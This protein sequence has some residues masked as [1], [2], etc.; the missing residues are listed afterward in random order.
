M[1]AVASCGD[2]AIDGYA[3]FVAKRPLCCWCSAFFLMIVMAVIGPIAVF[4][5]KE[6]WAIG[7]AAEGFDPRG[8]VLAGAI[9]ARFRYLPI[10]ECEG[11]I[12]LMPDGTL[13]SHYNFYFTDTDDDNEIRYDAY[14]CHANFEESD[15]GRRLLSDAHQGH[16]HQQPQKW[17]QQSTRR[18]YA[19]DENL[20]AD[21]LAYD[22]WSGKTDEYMQ[23]VFTGDDLF[24]TSAIQGVCEADAE[25]R[26]I[27]G[28]DV[29]DAGCRTQQGDSG[30]GDPTVCA[31]SRSIG[32]YL[33][34]IKGYASCSEITD[35]DVAEMKA[36]VTTCRT[37][38]D[39][40]DL[41]G[42]CWDWSNGAYTTQYDDNSDAGQ[43]D[44]ET[45]E[46]GCATYNAYYDMFYSLAE[47]DYAG[48]GS[49]GAVQLMIPLGFNSFDWSLEAWS[50]IEAFSGR[51]YGGAKITA[52]GLD[53]KGDLFTELM[54]ADSYLVALVFLCV[55]IL[56]V[57]HSGS[58][59]ISTCAFFEMMM[60]FLWAFTF[61]EV[62]LW[63]PFF[64]F[65]NGVSLFLI[66]G[67]GADD[68][69]VYMD[70][71]KQSFA[72]LGEVPL[73]QRVAFT[74]KRAG[75]A[76][77]VTSLTTSSSFFAN[78][79][80]PIPALKCFGL[81]SG[82]VIIA[83]FFLMLTFLPAVVVM[84]E[85][86]FKETCC[87]CPCS[88]TPGLFEV[89]KMEP[90]EPPKQRWC[91]RVLQDYV[92]PVLLHPL[93][94]VAFVGAALGVA[95]WLSTEAP[96]LDRPETDYMQLLDEDHPIE[97]FEKT[98]RNR[99]DNAN[100][101]EGYFEFNYVFGVK[102]EDNGDPFEPSD[103]GSAQYVD[104]NVATMES[105]EWVDNFCESLVNDTI[106]QVNDYDTLEWDFTCYMQHFRQ[107]MFTDCASTTD[108]D[109]AGSV[110]YPERTT[111]CGHTAFPFSENDFNACITEWAL[112]R[113]DSDYDTGLWFDT[114]GSGDIKVI[115]IKGLATTKYSDVYNIGDA[116]YKDGKDFLDGKTSS[117]PAGSGLD[118]GFFSSELWFYSLQDAITEGAY[119]S[120]GLSI[121]LALAVILM[122]SQRAVAST[123]A[124]TTI[125][126]IVLSVT[127][128][129]VKEGWTLGVIESVV[130]SLAVGLSCDFA[131]HLSHAFVHGAY[132]QS[133]LSFFSLRGV[134]GLLGAAQKRATRAITELGVTVLMGGLTTLITGCWLLL[135]RVYFYQQFG[136]FLSC[137]MALSVGYSFML[138]MPL[139]ATLGWLDAPC[140]PE[141]L[142]TPQTR[143]GNTI[144]PLSQKSIDKI[145]GDSMSV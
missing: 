50:D 93:G 127:G 94:R 131:A 108:G 25:L 98:W 90:F 66:I 76:M 69:F 67:I 116:F 144:E 53:I 40:F 137:L 81:F 28:F 44:L 70:A 88:C 55:Y 99:F 68:V 138:L 61:Y 52:I 58:F 139:L 135:A 102:P 115:V 33:A 56:M 13:T 142:C 34:A 27:S 113:G 35:D 89:P 114:D 123:L 60:A 8:T 78:V 19:Y 112:G 80:T 119:Q 10:A 92:A 124:A 101:D 49:L 105:Q 32:N 36:N 106:S 20:V 97:K 109:W 21:T 3:S 132:L 16:H 73:E 18:L 86:Y 122:L 121:I 26:S 7:G 84:H 62:F 71:W 117:A 125:L 24:T 104:L 140:T 45:A 38:F 39:S 77:L 87:C 74:L 29:L 23:V 37:L 57:V 103:Y 31:A 2:K 11:E 12:S 54:I 46:E 15:S 91:E 95:V 130:F 128:I 72:E 134:Q 64:P 136:L 120:A 126:L 1:G 59:W 107:W 110:L 63:R 100:G 22:L 14:N 85:A 143:D 65:L 111:C 9:Y 129:I 145:D 17:E 42:N 6:D 30:A 82:L 133:E 48:S 141:N 4:T 83:D 5:I 47:S 41:V 51:S 75:S 118:N 96:N 43:C 79:I